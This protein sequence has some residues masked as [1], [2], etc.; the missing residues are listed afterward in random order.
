M[1]LFEGARSI[2][3]HF[4]LYPNRMTAAGD[5]TTLHEHKQGHLAVFTGLGTVFTIAIDNF[6]LSRLQIH[7]DSNYGSPIAISG[8]GKTSLVFE[9]SKWHLATT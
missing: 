4:H 1:R 2:D 6:T 7:K 9:N 8:G 5:E 3:N